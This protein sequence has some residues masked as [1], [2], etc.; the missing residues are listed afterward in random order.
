MARITDSGNGSKAEGRL[1]SAAGALSHRVCAQAIVTLPGVRPVTGQ[2]HFIRRHELL[3]FLTQRPLAHYVRAVY[4]IPGRKQT[5]AI[6]TD[7]VFLNLEQARYFPPGQA[8]DGSSRPCV[9]YSQ[10]RQRQDSWPSKHAGQNNPIIFL[11]DCHD[12]FT[13]S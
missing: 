4:R 6:T 11:G 7:S 1:S 3:G 8:P 5:V 9:P 13:S 12:W 10:K 2:Q